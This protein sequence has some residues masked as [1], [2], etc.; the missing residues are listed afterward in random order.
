MWRASYALPEEAGKKY[1]FKSM[2]ERTLMMAINYNANHQSQQADL[3][4]EP[5]GLHGYKVFDIAKTGDIFRIGYEFGQERLA[6]GD[7]KAFTN[8]P[9]LESPTTA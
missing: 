7:L 4:W 9:S 2:M 6:A 1:N 5:P 8:S 3:L